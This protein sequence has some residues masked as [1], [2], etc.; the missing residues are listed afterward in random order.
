MSYSAS[1]LKFDETNDVPMTTSPV[2][3]QEFTFDESFANSVTE[4]K[5]ILRKVSGVEEKYPSRKTSAIGEVPSRKASAIKGTA[6]S[7]Q[8][9]VAENEKPP[10][11]KTSEVREKKPLSR[12]SSEIQETGPPSRKTSEMDGGVIRR[13]ASTVQEEEIPSRKSSAIRKISSEIKEEGKITEISPKSTAALE[14][15]KEEERTK[16]VK[17]ALFISF[18]KLNF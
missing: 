10:S 13:E 11:R 15:V 7:R 4:D 3:N 12:K 16:L 1:S 14:S 8:A 5:V 2:V 9:S 6:F 18:S 17:F